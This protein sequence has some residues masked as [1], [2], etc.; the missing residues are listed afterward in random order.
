MS[1]RFRKIDVRL[2]SD[3]KFRV[4]SRDAK[5]IFVFLLSCPQQSMIGAMRAT[6]P[7]LAAELQMTEREFRAAFQELTARGMVKLNEKAALVWLPNWLRYNRP[8]SPNVVKCWRTVVQVL[9][10][11]KL[12]DQIVL[13]LK[14][15][16]EGLPEAWRHP[17]L[18]QEQEQEQ[19][20]KDQNQNP[21]KSS[22]KVDSSVTLF[23]SLRAH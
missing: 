14:A 1:A 16:A 9:P 23:P 2:W 6:I 7:G 13:K 19:E 4:L 22:Q 18:N 20:Q 12:K 10:E 21:R 17:F 5:L 3:E 8:E 15:F 11:C